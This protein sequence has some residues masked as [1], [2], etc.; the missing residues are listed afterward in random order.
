MS[1]A[2]ALGLFVLGIGL[3]GWIGCGSGPQAPS[4]TVQA[5]PRVGPAA[6]PETAAETTEV[7]SYHYDPTG[8]PDPFQSYILEIA[9]RRKHQSGQTPLERFDLS[10]L[11]LTAVVWSDE[12]ARALIRDPSGKGYIVGEGAPVGKNEGR[13]ISIDDGRV[14]VKETYV[15]SEG[16]AT[17]KD[18]ELRLAGR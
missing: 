13:I 14:R 11:R 15:N 2:G 9:Q 3:L 7:S 17:T 16:Q 8:K 4:P 18:V 10:Q 6:A 1:Q 5:H 12:V